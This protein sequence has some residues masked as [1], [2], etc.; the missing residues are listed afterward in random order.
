MNL[1]ALRI[2]AFKDALDGAVLTCR[3]HALKD[4]EQRPAILGVKL[5]LKI[6][7]ALPVGVENLLD[8]VLVEPALLVGLVR[9]QMKLARTV[10]AE[11]RHKR[12]QSIAERLRRL[13]AHDLDDGLRCAS[14]FSMTLP[15]IPLGRKMM[16]STSNTP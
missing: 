5:F 8:L 6:A 12:L 3:I 1:A 11:R 9:P 16:N 13:L 14:S 15:R 4:H 10:N 7:Q 2:D